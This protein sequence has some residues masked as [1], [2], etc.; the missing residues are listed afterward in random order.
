[1]PGERCVAL[2]AAEELKRIRRSAAEQAELHRAEARP[3]P[4]S[5]AV[6]FPSHAHLAA[7]LLR[8]AARLICVATY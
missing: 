4:P 2:D 1:V 3:S 5:R 7:R 8:L 6:S